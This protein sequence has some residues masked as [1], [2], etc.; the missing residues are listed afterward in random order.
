MS[1]GYVLTAEAR[2]RVGKGSARA[3]RRQGK[4]P[5]VIYGDSKPPVTIA[6]PRKDVFMQMQAGGFMT[7]VGEID[8]DGKKHK[9]LA[10]D[11]QL[12]PV[13]DFVLHV[14]FLRISAKSIV[15]VNIPVHF[16]NEDTC[17]G[18]KMGGVL[19]IVRHEVEVNTPAD[20]I[21]EFFT[22]DLAT[23]EVGDTLKISSI[24]L[25]EGVEPTITDRDFTIAT[26]AAPGG[27][28]ADEED[29]AEVAPDEVEATEQDAGDD[30]D[31][32]EE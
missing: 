2:D 8:V 14:D 24:T 22:I 5:A 32:G 13:K 7:T 23:A 4:I 31:K 10:K 25:P 1:E 30:E 27:G 11:Y 28:V 16:E 26:I 15:T 6:L 20:S 19:N 12:D 21:P 3:V 9:V 17:P 18:I 29:E